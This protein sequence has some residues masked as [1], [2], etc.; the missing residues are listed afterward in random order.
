MKKNKQEILTEVMDL[1]LK[2]DSIID[3]IIVTCE[4]YSIDID[5]ISH[6]I[7]Y[8]KEMKELIRQE[9]LAKNLLVE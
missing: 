8:S 7:R 4:K 6:Y 9:G 5:T 3:A 1:H 2:C